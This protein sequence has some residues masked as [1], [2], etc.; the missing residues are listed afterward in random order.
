MSDKL[1]TNKKAANYSYSSTAFSN[2][3]NIK[4]LKI[5]LN[6]DRRSSIGIHFK[7]D[8]LI[9]PIDE[10]EATERC[11]STLCCTMIIDQT[12]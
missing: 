5:V 6:T 10:K 12:A 7:N 2:S 11:L 1:A 4:T 8:I 3:V 9:S